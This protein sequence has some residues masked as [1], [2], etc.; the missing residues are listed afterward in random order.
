LKEN[1]EKV[2]KQRLQLEK[3][4]KQENQMYQEIR[5]HL[6]NSLN[7]IEELE[8]LS[9]QL[10]QDIQSI[11]STSDNERQNRR[12]AAEKKGGSEINTNI[13]KNEEIISEIEQVVNSA[14]GP[15]KQKIFSIENLKSDLKNFGH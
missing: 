11:T 12:T 7:K 2:I 3:Q 13:E 1:T 8:N 4:E 9:K 6:Q 15:Q 5:K 14:E 10:E